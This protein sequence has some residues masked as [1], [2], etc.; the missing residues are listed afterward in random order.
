MCGLSENKE[1]HGIIHFT[2]L[3][4]MRKQIRWQQGSVRKYAYIM[5][6][7]H[8]SASTCI[9]SSQSLVV[10]HKI[11]V[12]KDVLKKEYYHVAKSGG[13]LSGSKSRDNSVLSKFINHVEYLA[14]KCWFSAKS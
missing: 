9:I 10:A 1:K 7:T 14:Q 8:K 12:K 6:T 2:F 4:G 11:L 3:H 5:Y 13:M